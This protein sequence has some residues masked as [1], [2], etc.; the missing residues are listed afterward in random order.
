MTA[1]STTDIALNVRAKTSAVEDAP[2]RSSRQKVSLSMHPQVCMKLM[3]RH[4]RLDPTKKKINDVASIVEVNPRT[5]NIESDHQGRPSQQKDERR[6][7][8]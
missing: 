4:H 2:E 6:K 1:G 7:R 5:R 8:L 3:A